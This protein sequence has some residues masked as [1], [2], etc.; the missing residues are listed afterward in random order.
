MRFGF[1]PSTVALE[2]ITWVACFVLFRIVQREICRRYPGIRTV[3]RLVYAGTALVAIA[4]A[5]W[6]VATGLRDARLLGLVNHIFG[7]GVFAQTSL[8]SLLILKWLAWGDPCA[9]GLSAEA[10]L[11]GTRTEAELLGCLVALS[12]ALRREQ[13]KTTPAH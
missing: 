11:L 7:M 6:V 4:P 12:A 9:A 13:D 10:P 5:A 8:R 3:C 2:F 1:L